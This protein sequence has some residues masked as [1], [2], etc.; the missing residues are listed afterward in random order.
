MVK[1]YLYLSDYKVETNCHG[2]TE[3]SLANELRKP[4]AGP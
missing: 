4:S 1:I 3:G 2:S